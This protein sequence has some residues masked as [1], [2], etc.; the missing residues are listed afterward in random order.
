MAER[1]L[2][3]TWDLQSFDENKSDAHDLLSIR[4]EFERKNLPLSRS[5]LIWEKSENWV[6]SGL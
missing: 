3:F 5:L 6:V 4:I 1:N 2:L